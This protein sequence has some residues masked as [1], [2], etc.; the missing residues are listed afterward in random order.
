LKLR[1]V[2]EIDEKRERERERERERAALTVME[3]TRVEK[4]LFSQ[5]LN[6]SLRLFTS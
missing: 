4:R 1:S 2:T 5:F 6:E 3:G